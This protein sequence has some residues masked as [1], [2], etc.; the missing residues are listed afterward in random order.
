MH[1]FLSYSKIFPLGYFCSR[2]IPISE[3]FPSIKY[4][5]IL[6]GE[7]PYRSINKKANTN[8]NKTRYVYAHTASHHYGQKSFTKNYNLCRFTSNGLPS[9]ANYIS[10]F[11]GR[12]F[13]NISYL[14]WGLFGMMTVYVVIVLKKEKASWIINTQNV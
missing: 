5:C 4:M 1:R 3:D 12:F 8:P 7:K 2:T 11:H 6:L 9:I 13:L 14:L 10:Y